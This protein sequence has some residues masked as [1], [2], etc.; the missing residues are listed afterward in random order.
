VSHYLVR[1]GADSQ[2][3]VHAP[4]DATDAT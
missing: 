2:S 1:N 3:G 4:T